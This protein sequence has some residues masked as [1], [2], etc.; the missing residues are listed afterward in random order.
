MPAWKRGRRVLVG[1]SGGISA[2]KILDYI[3]HLRRLDCELEVILTKGAE[4]FVSPLVVSTLTGRRCWLEED[5]LDPSRG[6][7][8]PHISLADWAEVFVIAPCTANVLSIAAAGASDTLLGA[9]LLAVRCPVLIFPAMN[10]HMWEHKAT[11][12]NL[13]TCA[14]WGYEVIPPEEGALACGYEGKGRLPSTGVLV[15]HTWRALCPDKSFRGRSFLI[16]A[17]PTWEFI[18]PVRFISNPSSGKMGVEL[19]RAAWYRGGDVT[20]ICGP[21]VSV[22]VPGAKVIP[23]ISAEDMLLR[24]LENRSADVVIKAAAVGDYRAAA[25]SSSKIKREGRGKLTLDLVSNPDIAARLGEGKRE[26]QILVGFAAETDNLDENA[27][28]KMRSKGLDAIVANDVTEEG[29]G[30]G[31]DTNRVVMLDRAGGRFEFSG[32]KEDVSHLIL[33]RVA[34]MMEGAK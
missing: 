33:D 2:Y 32:T 3:R 31:V 28:K 25:P 26:S 13:L 1:V 29:S 11:Q 20:L 8:I 15:E 34:A 17:G 9:A 18:D 27:L 14:Q 4:A 6:Y 30:F 16:T 19:A 23:V 21:G 5:F 24:C 7:Q 22:D 12:R 10:V